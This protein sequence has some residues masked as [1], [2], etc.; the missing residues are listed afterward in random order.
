LWTGVM[1]RAEVVFFMREN[2]EIPTMQFLSQFKTEP[3]DQQ[4]IDDAG[5]LYRNWNPGHGIDPNDAILAASAMRSGGMIFTLNTKHY[6][7]KD[8]LVTRAW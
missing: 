2:E 5:H 4:L 7:M 8:L 3:V 1:Q 6:P